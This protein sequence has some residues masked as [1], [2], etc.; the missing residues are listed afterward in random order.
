MIS[1][2]PGA[3]RMI[4]MNYFAPYNAE[5]GFRFE[6]EA[7]YNNTQP[8]S[9]YMVLA[10][11]CPTAEVYLPN[12]T[13]PPADVRLFSFSILIVYCFQWDWL[14]EQCA[15]LEVCRW[16]IH[17]AKHTCKDWN[18]NHIWCQEIGARLDC[19]WKLWILSHSYIYSANEWRRES[20][21]L[22]YKFR[23]ILGNNTLILTFST[24]C[25]SIK[26]QSQQIWLH[27]YARLRTHWPYS[28]SKPQSSPSQIPLSS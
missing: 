22:L 16:A 19:L 17:D 25:P 4:D 11:L 26:E 27:N 23:Y 7:I 14:V 12:R 13:A 8:S 21:G 2:P 10:S 5:V 20:R 1:I 15:H 6:V 9:L 28:S 18:V 3:G 24:S